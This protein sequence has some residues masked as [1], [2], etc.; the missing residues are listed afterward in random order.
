MY[1]QL[2]SGMRLSIRVGYFTIRWGDHFMWKG[3][4]GTW[5][6][7]TQ[8]PEVFPPLSGETSDIGHPFGFIKVTFPDVGRK[9]RFRP[10]SSGRRL[11]I[12]LLTG[13]DV[14]YPIDPCF[15]VSW[16]FSP[17]KQLLDVFWQKMECLVWIHVSLYIN[18]CIYIYYITYLVFYI[19]IKICFMYNRSFMCNCKN[20]HQ[21]LYS[22]C[23]SWQAFLC[24]AVYL[25]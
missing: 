4:V 5:I 24:A 1:L 3:E 14:I 6:G 17:S 8:L 11:S 21:R 23:L 22:L 25:I 2:I 15:S 7:R 19:V 16:K 20:G 18:V 12:Y 9:F 13:V 10:V